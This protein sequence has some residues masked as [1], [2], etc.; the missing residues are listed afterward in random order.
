M[1]RIP[2]KHI[3]VTE[4]V[5]A[6]AATL[7]GMVAAGGAVVA[8]SAQGAASAKSVWDAVY[9][10]DQAKRGQEKYTEKCTAC[11]QA[12]LSGSDQAPG[13][14]GG[15]FLDRWNDQSVGDLADRIRLTMPQDD[16]GSINVQMSA[17]I[18]AYLL[19]VNNFPAGA[20]E[21]KPDRSAMKSVVI[22]RK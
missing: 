2:Q 4:T 8:L 3:R 9:S 7:A 19:Q 13:L 17:D 21:L 22:K 15:E 11:H 16:I 12:D 20:E 18:T 5:L 10:Q 1:T 14:A 6:A